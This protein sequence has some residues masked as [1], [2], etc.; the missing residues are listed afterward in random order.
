MPGTGRSRGRRGP[1]LRGP[2]VVALVGFL[3]VGLFDDGR[4]RSVALALVAVW[5]LVGLLV[6]ALSLARESGHLPHHLTFAAVVLLGSG[7]GS[8]AWRVANGSMPDTAVTVL[9]V[10]AWLG[11]VWLGSRVVYGG[12]F[13]RLLRWVAPADG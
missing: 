10:G 2:A 5:L 9:A 8:T 3:V 11:S 4:V 12:P 13:D 6:V 7:A 1:P